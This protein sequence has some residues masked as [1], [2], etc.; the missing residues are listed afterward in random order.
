MAIGRI[1]LYFS[2]VYILLGFFGVFGLVK[3]ESELYQSGKGFPSKSCLSLMLYIHSSWWMA[4]KGQKP[5]HH[6]SKPDNLLGPGGTGDKWG[7]KPLL[8]GVEKGGGFGG[9]PSLVEKGQRALIF[10]PCVL[11]WPLITPRVHKMPLNFLS[12]AMNCMTKCSLHFKL[13]SIRPQ[14][15][16]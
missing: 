12:W 9:S 6:S 2:W 10:D 11:P 5:L 8:G 15:G 13:D 3:P 7:L 14:I 1:T 16:T 4:E